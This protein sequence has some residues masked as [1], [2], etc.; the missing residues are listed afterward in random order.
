MK[1]GA[2]LLLCLCTLLTFNSYSQIDSY[3]SHINK[4]NEFAKN[5]ISEIKAINEY[6]DAITINPKKYNA[7]YYRAKVRVKHSAFYEDALRDINTAIDLN[8]TYSMLYGERAQIKKAIGF[9][10]K[11]IECGSIRDPK[12]IIGNVE[13]HDAFSDISMAINICTNNCECNELKSINNDLL[14][15]RLNLNKNDYLSL[16]DSTKA[17]I[18]NIYYGDCKEKNRIFFDVNFQLGDIYLGAGEYENALYHYKRGV[19][20]SPSINDRLLSTYS[21]LLIEIEKGYKSKWSTANIKKEARDYLFRMK[22]KDS[23]YTWYNEK[24][25]SE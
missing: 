24:I 19:E 13:L 9:K 7:Y 16:I 15:C 4:G 23:N 22:K 17:L 1:K 18:E 2:F 12:C 5:E 25:F 21:D 20:M 3:E 11:I 6:T 10:K 8:P 14:L